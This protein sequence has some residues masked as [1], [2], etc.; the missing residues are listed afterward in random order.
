MR[1]YSRKGGRSR[2][3]DEFLHGGKIAELIGGASG[4]RNAGALQFG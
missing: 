4:Q 3:A 1:R 2:T